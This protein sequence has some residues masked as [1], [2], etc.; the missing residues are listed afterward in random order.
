M[1]AR[2]EREVI[3]ADKLG[4]R[5]LRHFG[6]HTA[7]GTSPHATGHASATVIAWGILA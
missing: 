2:W 6:R 1:A 3:D 5:P 4:A 7:L